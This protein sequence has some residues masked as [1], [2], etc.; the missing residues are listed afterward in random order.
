M[1]EIK[2][3]IQDKPFVREIKSF[4]GIRQMEYNHQMK[5]I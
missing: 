4:I 2:Q 3:I 5:E 1:Y